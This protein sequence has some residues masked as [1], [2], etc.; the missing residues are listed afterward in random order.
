MKKIN[1]VLNIIWFFLLLFFLPT[2]PTVHSEGVTGG[3]SVA[4]AVD[5]G[6]W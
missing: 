5:V 6:D 4:V 1:S 2:Q 3:G